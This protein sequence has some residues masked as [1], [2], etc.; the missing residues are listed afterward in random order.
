MRGKEKSDFNCNDCPDN[1]DDI[2]EYYMVLDSVWQ[3]AMKQGKVKMLCIGCLE[4]RLGRLLT[5]DDFTL[6][7]LNKD[8]RDYQKSDRLLNRLGLSDKFR[9]K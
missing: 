5:K 7:P 3:E 8:T 4:K 9:G 1:V 2:C 6:C